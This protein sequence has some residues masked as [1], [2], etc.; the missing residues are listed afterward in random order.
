MKCQFG[1]EKWGSRCWSA[2]TQH[3][4]EQGWPSSSADDLFSLP[5]PLLSPEFLLR[6]HH[7]QQY[8]LLSTSLFFHVQ[9]HHIHFKLYLLRLYHIWV[10]EASNTDY[11]LKQSSDALCVLLF[12]SFFRTKSHSWHHLLACLN[13]SCISVGIGGFRPVLMLNV[14]LFS[15]LVVVQAWNKLWTLHNSSVSVEWAKFIVILLTLLQ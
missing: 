5:R 9:F 7:V 15:P 6:C 11:F 2:E 10:T 13:G 3:F 12:C 4:T 14:D 8:L 1:S